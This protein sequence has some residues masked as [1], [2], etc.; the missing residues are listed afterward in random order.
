MQMQI[1]TIFFLLALEVFYFAFL[2]LCIF[3]SVGLREAR[4]G[5]VSKN[6]ECAQQLLL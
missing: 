3:F 4:R 6:G 2:H 1:P 5:A